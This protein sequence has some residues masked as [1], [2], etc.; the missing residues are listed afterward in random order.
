MN[1][2]ECCHFQVAMSKILQRLPKKEDRSIN[3]H[4]SADIVDNVSETYRLVR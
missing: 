3:G 2:Y 4:H 1:I